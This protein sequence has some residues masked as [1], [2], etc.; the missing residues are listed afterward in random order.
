MT[1]DRN[2]RLWVLFALFLSAL[3]VLKIINDRIGREI[4]VMTEG[5]RQNS[6]IAIAPAGPSIADQ[7]PSLRYPRAGEKITRRDK[8][9]PGRDYIESVFYLNKEEIARQ[10][11]V[12]GKTVESSGEIPRGRV[13]FVDD[14]KNT[15][16]AEHYARGKKEGSSQTYFAD[17]RMNAE[18]YY[19]QGKLLWKKEYY[20]DGAIR[21]E[22]NYEDA[23]EN[24]DEK[25]TGIGKVY[26]R[27]GTLKYEW[28][29]TNSERI[30]FRK[31]YNQDGALRAAFYFD[32][33]GQPVE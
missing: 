4:A 18:A 33:H 19:R 12:N 10:K 26:Y 27:D 6:S 20:N 28:N 22:L 14:S 5:P 16:G 31:S 2:K 1:N 21:I 30:G 15:Y 13:D 11:I 17:G 23:R 9:S 29:L 24:A 7:N 25:E 32:E 8:L 3:A